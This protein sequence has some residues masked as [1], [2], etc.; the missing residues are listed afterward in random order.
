MP[1]LSLICDLRHSLRQHRI[2]NPLSEARDGT[3]NLMVCSRI[4]LCFATMGT[5]GWVFLLCKKNRVLGVLLWYSGL[6]IWCCHCSSLGRCCGMGFDPWP[7][8][9]HMPWVWG[10]KKKPRVLLSEGV[11]ECKRHNQAPGGYLLGSC[12]KTASKLH[13][14][15]LTP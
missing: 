1:D 10:K 8:N 5:P 2:L 9:F 13:D 11:G 7:W 6:R 4:H 12:W 14:K 15:S 3:H